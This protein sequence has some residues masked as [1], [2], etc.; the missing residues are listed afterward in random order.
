V[1]PVDGAST[2]L[3]ID[4]VTLR[5][6]VEAR[7]FV[8]YLRGA[9]R[10]PET[11]R[12]YA[13]RLGRFFNWCQARPVDFRRVSVLDLAAYKHDLERRLTPVG[14][15]P[16]TGKTINAHLTAVLEFLR[17]GAA[18]GLIEAEVVER[19]AQR[20]FVSHAPAG[21]D[22][23]EN[24]QF[25]T[26]TSPAIKAREITLPP[27]TLTDKQVGAVLASCR[28]A[29]DR[30]LVTLLVDSGMFSRGQPANGAPV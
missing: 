7:A 24:G 6:H 14:S 5:P 11:I 30:F 9:G 29:R 20:R 28:T 25:R 26:V 13:P 21:F 12:A 17:F 2:Y 3:V 1:S 4:E 18:Y 23:G 8:L 27:E 16:I 22:G 10:S 19:L 15:R